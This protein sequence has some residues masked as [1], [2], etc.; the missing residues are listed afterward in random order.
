MRFETPSLSAEHG[1]NSPPTGRVM[2]TARPETCRFW[3]FGTAYTPLSLHQL[4]TLHLCNKDFNKGRV[5]RITLFISNQ[6]IQVSS[7]KTLAH[8]YRVY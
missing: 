1:T 8:G 3:L 5:A 6:S 2:T 4:V 7:P